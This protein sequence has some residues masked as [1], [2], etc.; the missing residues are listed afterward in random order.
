ME[1]AAKRDNVNLGYITRSIV[2]KR[3]VTLHFL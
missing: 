1:V 3:K 2:S